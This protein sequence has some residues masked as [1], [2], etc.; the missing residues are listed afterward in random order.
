MFSNIN[1]DVHRKLLE[2]TQP[3]NEMSGIGTLSFFDKC[4]IDWPELLEYMKRTHHRKRNLVKFIRDVKGVHLGLA[5]QGLY[6]GLSGCENAKAMLASFQ[7]PNFVELVVHVFPRRTQYSMFLYTPKAIREWIRRHKLMLDRITVL[8]SVVHVVTEY[9]GRK[10]N[11]LIEKTLSALRVDPDLLQTFYEQPYSSYLET[12]KG[13]KKI[14]RYNYPDPKPL[15]RKA[16]EVE[17][18]SP[19]R[20]CLVQVSPRS[21]T[22]EY[23]GMIDGQLSLFIH[24]N[25]F[26][27]KATFHLECTREQ[28][29]SGEIVSKPMS[30]TLQEDGIRFDT[31][32]FSHHI[33]EIFKNEVSRFLNNN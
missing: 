29:A 2:T 28:L 32:L 6:D 19:K 25:E 17:G 10:P 26:P 3:S 18:P 27:Q 16:N 12:W 9:K 21:V 30:I 33:A 8:L 7:L 4:Q 31:V 11:A 13:R 24:V 1:L 15:K 23:I 14:N 22:I 20:S 5:C